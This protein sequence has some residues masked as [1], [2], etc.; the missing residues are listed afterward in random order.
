MRG[1]NLKT[2][3]TLHPTTRTTYV[4]TIIFPSSDCMLNDDWDH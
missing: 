4:N 1:S 2:N 3:K